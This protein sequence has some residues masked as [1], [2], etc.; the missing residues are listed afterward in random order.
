VIG[1]LL[2]SSVYYT[3]QKQIIAELIEDVTAKFYMD[4]DRCALF[5]TV[6]RLFV[7][8]KRS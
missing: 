5:Q 4:I 7:F 6:V 3:T 2:L 1:G 8:I